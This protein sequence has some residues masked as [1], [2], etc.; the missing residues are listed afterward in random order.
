MSRDSLLSVLSNDC[1]EVLKR[2]L[3]IFGAGMTARLYIN[4]LKRLEKDGLYIKGYIDNNPDKWGGEFD[5]KEIVSLNSLMDKKEDVFILICSY[6]SNVINQIK[7]HR[8]LLEI[9]LMIIYY[10]LATVI[11]PELS[12][13]TFRSFYT[14]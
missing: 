1:K 10:H 13:L 5:G 12:N 14:N 8:F 3:W 11:M 2:E 4:G 9:H 7:K 6:Y